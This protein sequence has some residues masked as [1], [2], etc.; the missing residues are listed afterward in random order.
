[1][2]L[3]RKILLLQFILLMGMSGYTQKQTFDVVS[4]A[5]PGG[6]QQQQKEAFLQL[7]VMDEKTGA[8]SI[9]LITKAIA[10][11]ATAV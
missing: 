4:Y 9:A 11:E 3:L 6:W 8:Y 1:M 2:H 5:V 10:S 7:S